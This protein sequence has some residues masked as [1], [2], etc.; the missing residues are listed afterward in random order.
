MLQ[1]VRSTPIALP[2][3]GTGSPED[4]ALLSPM[5]LGG[6]QPMGGCPVVEALLLLEV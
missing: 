4:G 6:M 2:G 3:S 5:L 1:N